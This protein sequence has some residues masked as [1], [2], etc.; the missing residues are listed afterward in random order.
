MLMNEGIEVVFR[1]EM[2]DADASIDIGTD[3]DDV[4]R[5]LEEKE[6]KPGKYEAS[7]AGK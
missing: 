7:E 3:V 1:H 4:F 6:K 2:L 5:T